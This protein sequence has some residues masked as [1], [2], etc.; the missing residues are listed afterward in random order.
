M[1]TQATAPPQAPALSPEPLMQMMQGLQAT[2]IL[3]AGV[4]LGVFDQIAAGKRDAGSI[5]GAVDADERGVRI[6]LDALT[7]LQLLERKEGYDLAPL[8]EAFLVSDRPAYLGGMLSIMAGEWAWTGYP[9]LAEAVR[10]GGTV[11]EEAAEKPSHSFWETFAR[12][13]TGVA[14]PASVL[15][16]EILGPWAAA[17]ETLEVLD[18]AAGSG[19]YSLTLAGQ[20]EHAGI[21]LVDWPNVLE[22]TLRTAERLGLRDRTS[23]IEGSV[24]DVPLGGPYDLVI[25][26]H[27]FH[28]FSEERCLTLMRRL[29]DAL[30]PGGKLAIN[31]FAAADGNVAEDP[32]PS[33]FSVIMLVW[34]QEGEAH[35]VSTY[36]RLLEQTGFGPPEVHEGRGMPSRFLIAER[37]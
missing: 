20:Q 14:T 6:L 30:K 18:V 7:A 31:E 2:A 12:S 13:S 24:F 29:A 5:A 9:R 23:S 15:L 16:A 28:H 25:A 8:A 26:S 37:L 22:V 36:R 32:F 11:L 35:P 4:Q 3:Q 27:I 10:T 19:L 34:T 21:T 33:L 1:S 17:R